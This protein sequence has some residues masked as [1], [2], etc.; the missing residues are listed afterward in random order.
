MYTRIK[1][2]RSALKM[3]QAEFAQH[4]GLGQSTLAMIEVGKRTFSDKHI[5]II[6]ATFNVNEEWLRTGKGEIFNSS[7]YEN[8][9]IDIFDNL[10]PETQQYLLVMAKELLNTQ[11]KLLSKK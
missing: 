2:I 9:L 1:A 6:C 10:N 4:L 3:N 5:K 11:Q 7:L 8:E